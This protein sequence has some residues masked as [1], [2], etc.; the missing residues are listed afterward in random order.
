MVRRR[1]ARHAH[2]QPCRRDLGAVQKVGAQKA[3]RDKEVEHEHEEGRRDLRAVVGFRERGRNGQCKH[4]RRH[5]DARE[6]EELAA[7]KPVDGEEGDEAGEEFPGEGSAGEDTGGFGVEAEALLEDDLGH[8]LT[9]TSLKRV[10]ILAYGRVC[11]DQVTSAH[12]LQELQEDTQR[13]AIE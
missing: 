5:A 9:F 4:A 2:A 6:H 7:P 10:W 11:G 3:N 8:A 1:N 12:L 13:E